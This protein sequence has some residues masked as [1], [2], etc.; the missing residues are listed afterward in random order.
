MTRSSV[1]SKTQ[2]TAPSG[3]GSPG[4]SRRGGRSP[5]NGLLKLLQGAHAD[6]AEPDRSVVALEAE[7]PLWDVRAVPGAARRAGAFEVL[8]DDGPVEDDPLEPGVAD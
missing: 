7:R 3:G 2:G 4:A 8:V 1:P 5:E 6:V